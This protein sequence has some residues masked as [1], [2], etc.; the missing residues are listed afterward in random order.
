MYENATKHE[1]L[2]EGKKAT[3]IVPTV[4]ANGRWVWKAEYF[5]AFPNFEVAMVEK[6]YHVCFIEHDNRWATHDEVERSAAFLRYVAETYHLE[7]RGVPVGMSCG[8]L[9]AA[10]LA[11]AHP[12]LIAV[13]YLDAPVLNILSMAGLG[14]CPANEAIRL[15]IMNTFRFSKSSLISFRNSPIDHMDKLIDNNIPI[16]LLYGN[17]DPVVMY[18]ENGQV[19][20]DF[21]RA[22]GGTIK[23]VCKSMVGHH[24]HGLPDPQ[25]I[26][27]FVE[28]HFNDRKK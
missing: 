21:Y 1:F 27:D 6:G 5:E 11:E 14:E 13:L 22:Q 20:E 26:I 17:A 16:I 7:Q 3:V 10:Q 4:P 24:P 9:L 19:L 12:E 25:C 2:F 28:E 15:E 8:G 18:A 23:T